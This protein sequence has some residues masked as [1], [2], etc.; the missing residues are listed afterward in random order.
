MSRTEIIGKLKEILLAADDRNRDKVLACTE[1]SR[2]V[3]DLGFS[4]VSM[5]YMV[6][7]IEEEMDIRFENVG[8][9]DFE[10]L[11]DVVNYIEAKLK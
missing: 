10:T 6:I 1:D 2:L 9:S 3:A 4:S 11:G 5:L 7:A 8:A